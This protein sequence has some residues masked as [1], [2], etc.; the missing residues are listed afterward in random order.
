[1]KIVET[2][3]GKAYHLSP[4]TQLEV[5][6][7]NLFFNEYGEQ[8]LPVTLPDTDRNRKL[9]GYAHLPA[10]RQKQG[11]DIEV[12]IS[13]GSFFTIA[14]QVILGA[15]ER[16]GIDTTFYLNEGAFLSRIS[17]TNLKD[18]FKDEYILGIESVEQALDWM[19]GLC[20]NNNRH[21]I[22]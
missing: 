18:V 14:K 9:C 19:E 7:T 4:D 21:Y 15:K 8:S 3:S 11:R 13:E 16:D 22:N 10:N 17:N 20:D 5:E 6:R 1:M 2:K 12:S